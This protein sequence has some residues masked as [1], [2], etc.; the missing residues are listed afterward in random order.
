M[1]PHLTGDT[2]EAQQPHKEEDPTRPD[3]YIAWGIDQPTTQ[4]PLTRAGAVAVV[5]TGSC[6][7]ML[8][9]NWSACFTLH[10][11]F[12]LRSMLAIRSDRGSYLR[13]TGKID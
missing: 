13:V 9:M 12:H 8:R 11:F 1:S 5:R 2:C 10:G 4:R 3:P 7:R 6:G